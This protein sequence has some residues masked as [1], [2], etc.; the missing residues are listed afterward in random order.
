MIWVE[1]NCESFGNL[2]RE[3]GPYTYA[4]L[5]RNFCP[6]ETFDHAT[7]QA[8]ETL[9]SLTAPS[10]WGGFVEELVALR[11][12]SYMHNPWMRQPQGEWVV[13]KPSGEITWYPFVY[14]ANG[15]LRPP[16]I[17]KE[18]QVVGM[19]QSTTAEVD[20]PV[21]LSHRR[22]RATWFEISKQW[23]VPVIILN[24]IGVQ[25][26]DNQSGLAWQLLWWHNVRK[27]YPLEN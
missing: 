27:C 22:D 21:T 8:R 5:T 3:S 4:Q 20:G 9:S 17:P 24:N 2:P 12:R 6:R 25:V 23:K 15:E 1:V 18:W 7:R 13:K 14:R 10:A 26:F 16:L 19:L 11:K